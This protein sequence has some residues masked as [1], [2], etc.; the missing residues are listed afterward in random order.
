MSLEPLDTAEAHD[1]PTVQQISTFLENRVGQL[2]RLTRLLE[3]T[4]VHIL[5]ISVVNSWDCAV[6][7][8][9]FDRPDE[10]EELFRSNGFAVS[11]CEMLVVSMPPGKRGLQAILTALMAGEVDLSYTYPLLVRPHGSPAIALASDNLEMAARALQ[12]HN[13]TVLGESDLE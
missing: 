12:S 7:R 11:R 3:R 13:L 5:A 9:I 4:D 8:M 2:A 6:I 10:A 1:F